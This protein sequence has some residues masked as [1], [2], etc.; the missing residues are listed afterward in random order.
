MGSFLL[1][2]RTRRSRRGLAGIAPFTQPTHREGIA[3]GIGVKSLLLHGWNPSGKQACI[4][5][6]RRFCRG[7]SLLIRAT[8]SLMKANSEKSSSD[9]LTCSKVVHLSK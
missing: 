2:R 9:S 1:P 8:C 6:S 7:A 3:A 4:R 5:H